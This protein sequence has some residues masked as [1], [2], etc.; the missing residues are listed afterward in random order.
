M[1]RSIAGLLHQEQVL[2]VPTAPPFVAAI[3]AFPSVKGYGPGLHIPG[4][5][6]R[7]GADGIGEGTGGRDGCGGGGG[8]PAT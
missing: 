3:G 4:W 2:P 1:A 6:Y 7:P 5:R 8:R